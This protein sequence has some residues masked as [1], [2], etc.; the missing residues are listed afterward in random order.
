MIL[1]ARLIGR[2]LSEELGQPFLVED[3]P[4]AGGNIATEA[5]VRAQADGYTLH[6]SSTIDTVNATLYDKL[7]FS[8]IRDMA[9]V[10]SIART[11]LVVVVNPS[12]PIKTVSALINYAKANPGKLNMASA[13]I[14]TPPHV[15]GELFKM[16]TGT[17]MQHVPYRG[18]APAVADLIG[19]QVQ[20]MLPSC[21]IVS[22]MLGAVSYAN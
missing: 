1:F 2:W 22:N 14:G 7:N 19:G 8:F 18:G 17:N 20:V 5:V 21:P 13:G 15:A 16:M 4:G 12:V 10:A 11:P 6:L 9:P 3:R